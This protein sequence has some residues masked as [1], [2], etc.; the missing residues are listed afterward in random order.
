MKKILIAG[1][2]LAIFAAPAV[3]QTSPP[4]GGSGDANS[5]SGRNS[6]TGTKSGNTG[7]TN[8]DQGRTSGGGGGGSGGGAGGGAG[9]GSGGGGN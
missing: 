3:A 7:T 6:P 2:A 5:M 8:S 1:V 4:P 9:G